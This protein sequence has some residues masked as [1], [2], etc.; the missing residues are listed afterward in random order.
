MTRYMQIGMLALFAGLVVIGC[1]GTCPSSDGVT[2]TR[3]TPGQME[4]F[5]QVELD[6]AF[7]KQVREDARAFRVKEEF[8]FCCAVFLSDIKM[9]KTVIAHF[10]THVPAYDIDD[11]GLLI[12]ESEDEYLVFLWERYTEEAQYEIEG[13]WYPGIGNMGE[14]RHREYGYLIDRHTLEILEFSGATE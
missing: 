12:L 13:F 4:R 9:L 7:R 14:Y 8:E 11:Y 2:I 1:A 5:T 3:Q 10:K 6:V